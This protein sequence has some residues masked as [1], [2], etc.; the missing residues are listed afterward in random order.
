MRHVKFGA[1]ACIGQSVYLYVCASPLPLLVLM[2]IA[3]VRGIIDR[4]RDDRR[5][6]EMTEVSVGASMFSYSSP[7][8]ISV[9]P[10]LGNRWRQSCEYTISS[11][12][13][14]VSPL[15]SIKLLT[16]SRASEICNLGVLFAGLM[17]IKSDQI[18]STRMHTNT[19]EIARTQ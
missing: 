14:V 10:T 7:T 17:M 12:S 3:W 13:R 11:E 16:A 6:E 1:Y 2:T 4:R 19:S 5:L 9:H 8:L 18:Y 15:G